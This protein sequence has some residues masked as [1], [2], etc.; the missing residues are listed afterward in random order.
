MAHGTW[1]TTGGGGDP[2]SAV[3]MAVAVAAVLLFGGGAA[4]A[5]AAA[6]TELLIVIA[7][8][9]GVV[10]ILGA[11]VLAW[12][13]LKGRPAGDARAEAGRLERAQAYAVEQ[14]ARDALAHQRA[15]EL[16]VAGRSVTQIV[17]D[18]AAIAAAALAGAERHPARVIRGEVE[19]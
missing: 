2:G 10:V 5:V 15:L 17:L 12:W 3:L 14:A 19:R 11:A 9:I 4:A 1:K 8:I 18:P 13:L 6:I 16:A 7:V